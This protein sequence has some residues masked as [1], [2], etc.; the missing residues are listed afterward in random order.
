[1]AAEPRQAAWR[2][3]IGAYGLRLEN[4]ERARALL[5]PAE[6][7]WPSLLIRR[8]R[9]LSESQHEWMNERAATLKLQNGGEILIDRSKGSA[10]FVLPHPVRTAELVHPL[11][12][13]VAA[14]MGYWLDRESFHAGGVVVDGRAWGILGERES[15]KSTMVA[16]LALVGAGIACDDMLVLDDGNVLSAPRS[17][18]LR[19]ESAERLG[20]GEFLG[21]VG[22]RERWRLRVAPVAPVVPLAGWIFLAW[23]ERV[24]AVPM[25]GTQRLVRLG[26]GRGVRLPPRDPARLLEIA[27]L[28]AWELRRPRR[29]ESLASSVD[30]LLETVA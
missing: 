2:R 3:A 22:A 8:K 28:P 18:D 14:V 10:T 19:R 11:L 21:V 9:G 26:E 5:L 17:V 23:G 29:W 16:Q 15:G 7:L 13:P 4:V 24:E 6:P 1:M 30:C 12:A 20:V 27:A 25:T